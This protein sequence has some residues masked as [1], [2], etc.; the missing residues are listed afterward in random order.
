M[1]L[2]YIF[3]SQRIHCRIYCRIYNRNN[4]MKTIKELEAKIGS[5]SNPSKMPSFAW[6]IPI[7]YCVTGSKLALVD[8]TICKKCY[9]GK[10]AMYF[11]LLKPCI[12][13]DTR[14]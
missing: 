5:L 2:F 14:H 10:G 11:L 4:N 3:V 6:G 12:K 7:E 8:G 1:V 9:A 13:E